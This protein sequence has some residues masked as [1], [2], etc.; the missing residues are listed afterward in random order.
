MI[1]RLRIRGLAFLGVEQAV[2][3]V[4]FILNPEVNV[5]LG[6]I[7]ELDTMPILRRAGGELPGVNDDL[8][9]R[10]GSLL[11][12]KTVVGY[13][14]FHYAQLTENVSGSIVMGEQRRRNIFLSEERSGAFNFPVSRD[15]QVR[16]GELLSGCI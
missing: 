2:F 11:V 7:A 14:S 15:T 3:A 16:H 1:N 6:I 5:E 10:L 13:R 9:L 4:G 12:M 8:H